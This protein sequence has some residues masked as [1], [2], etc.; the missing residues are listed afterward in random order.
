M[1]DV[2]TKKIR[3]KNMAAIKSADTKPELSIF[4]ELAK[5]KKVFKKHYKIN[6][7]SIDIASP[8]NK[9]AIFI[10]G[11]FW[12]GY[13]FSKLKKRLPKKYWLPKIRAN[14]KRDKLN[15][16]KLKK[17]GWKVL[18]IWE[19]EIKKDL[20]GAIRKFIKFLE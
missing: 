10:D 3:S 13:R 4:R 5:R 11:D 18:R 9:V 8:K 16:N 20:D 1:P 14:I 12:H 17:D 19:H 2:H 6:K 7:I 15:R